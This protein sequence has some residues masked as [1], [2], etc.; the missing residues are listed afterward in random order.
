M[1]VHDTHPTPAPPPLRLDEAGWRAL[2]AALLEIADAQ[3][4][5]AR[6]A[7]RVLFEA[8]EVALGELDDWANADTAWAAALE[9]SPH[10]GPA[11]LARLELAITRDAPSAAAG[12]FEAV[13]RAPE[14]ALERRETSAIVE[15]CLLAW[16]FRWRDL[17]RAASATEALRAA[18]GAERLV[19]PLEA[20]Y[21]TPDTQRARLEAAA[22]RASTTTERAALSAALGTLLLD[23]FDARDLAFAALDA[24]A[25]ESVD[26]AWL[27]C[28]ASAEVSDFRALVAALE[29]LSRCVPR[30]LAPSVL[31]VCGELCE[32]RLLDPMR[33]DA[34]YERSR[35]GSMHVAVSIRRVVQALAGAATSTLPGAGGAGLAVRRYA[36]EAAALDEHALGRV[37]AH[38]AIAHALRAGDASTAERLARAALARQPDDERA[39][40]TLARGAWQARRWAVFDELW[41][42]RPVREDDP[43]AAAVERLVRGAVAEHALFDLKA[44]A[45]AL[46]AQGGVH[47]A[48]AERDLTALRA[49]Q[50]VLV[51]GAPSERLRAWQHEADATDSPDR[52]LDLFLKIARSLLR[53]THE[54]EKALTYLLWVLDGGESPT[55]A[56]LAEVVGRARGSDRLFRDTL[57][58]ARTEDAVSPP[59][60]TAA[61][62]L[63]V[64]VELDG[65]P[66]DP[67][68]SGEVT[69]Y[70]LD[71][72]PGAVGN[73]AEV[74][75]YARLLSGFSTLP[76]TAIHTPV[77]VPAPSAAL[78]S[79]PSLATATPEPPPRQRGVTPVDRPAGLS[80]EVERSRDAEPARAVIA[81]KLKR[82]RASGADAPAASPW[83]TLERAALEPL[84]ARVDAAARER[85]DADERA[86]A[87]AALARGYEAEQLD[88]LATRAWAEVLA[89]RARD[90]DAERR[91]EALLRGQLEAPDD[92]A[93]RAQNS[94]LLVDVLLR[95]AERAAS[96]LEKCLALLDVSSVF[97]GPMRAPLEAA[98]ALRAVLARGLSPTDETPAGRRLRAERDAVV[99]ALQEG[100]HLQALMRLLAWP[101]RSAERASGE[102]ALHVGVLWMG[103]QGAPEVALPWLRRAA[104]TLDAWAPRAELAVCLARLGRGGEATELA[105][106]LPATL[107]EAGGARLRVADALEARGAHPD[108]TRALYIAAFDA[109]CAARPLLERLERG[110]LVAKDWALLAR[111]TTAQLDAAEARGRALQADATEAAAIERAALVDEQRDL[112]VRLGHLYAKRLEMADRAAEAFLRAYRLDPTDHGLLRVLEGLLARHAAPALQIE[113]YGLYLDGGQPGAREAYART[114]TLAGLLEQAG[115]AGDAIDRLRAL[116]RTPEVEATIERLLPLA[117]RW[118]EVAAT[119]R[120]RLRAPE[121]DHEALLRRLASVLETG[122]RD[123]TGATDALRELLIVRPDDLSVVKGL[124]RLLEGQRRWEALVEMSERELALTPDARPQAWILFRIG[125][126]YE[127]R[128]DR[129]EAA[130]RCYRRAV[131][132]DPRCFPALHGLREMAVA[133]GQW[134]A[135]LDALAREAEL[136]DEPRER[137]AIYARM[138]EVFERHLND[139]ARAM[140]EHRRAVATYPACLPSL[141]ALADD[142]IAR[143]AWDE[144]APWLQVL[145]AQNLDRWSKAQRAHVLIQR[146]QV[147]LHLSRR[148]EAAE[149]MRLALDLAPEDTQAL[150][151]LVALGPLT[152]GPEL[153]EVLARIARVEQGATDD[154]RR[155]QCAALR[156]RALARALAWGKADAAFEAARRLQPT[157][158]DALR[159]W[160][161]HLIATCRLTLAAEALRAFA[162]ALAAQGRSVTHGELDAIAQALRWA[163]IL[164]CDQLEAPE[165]GLDALQRWLEVCPESSDAQFERALCLRLLGRGREARDGLLTLLVRPESERLKSSVRARWHHALGRV[166]ADMLEDTAGALVHFEAAL[167][168]DPRCASAAL[169]W[170]RTTALVGG[171]DAAV[172]IDAWLRDNPHALEPPATPDP[173]YGLLCVFVAKHRRARGDRDGARSALHPLTTREGPTTRDAQLTLLEFAEA[174]GRLDDAL[175]VLAAMLARDVGDLD[176]LRRLA[177]LAARSG[178]DDRLLTTLDALGLYGSLEPAEA[179]RLGAL[180]QRQA[181]AYERTPRPVPE[182]LL[183]DQ[184]NHPAFESPL[185]AAL[186]ALEPGLAKV[187][188]EATPPVGRRVERPPA[189]WRWCVAL[190]GVKGATLMQSDAQEAPIAV[191]AGDGPA[192]VLGPRFFESG[193]SAAHRRFWLGHALWALRTGTARLHGLEAER[194]VEVMGVVE[195]LFTP[196][197]AESLQARAVFDA[198]PQRVADALGPEL[199][200]RRQGTL[201]A[202][203]TGESALAGVV[204]SGD[205]FGL[206]AS[207][208]LRAALECAAGLTPD[209]APDLAWV[210]RASPRM[211][212]LVRWGISE[213]CATLRSVTGLGP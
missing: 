103:P 54:H 24:S 164:W 43:H 170:L 86:D 66:T 99:A 2:Y 198:L 63:E 19:A 110:A 82:A 25:D 179:A 125:S 105:L 194:A 26:A 4:T 71:P 89:W 111:V 148:L 209:A 46:S 154:A 8:G 74:D 32:H 100:H 83:L 139:R 87:L 147:A 189:E 163:A 134:P 58:R 92:E 123:L 133:A 39:W 47:R 192:V 9:H 129:P 202:L 118:A 76:A 130:A 159:P 155:S 178:R 196:S 64:E 188:G 84:V 203:Y 107:P 160:I 70:P 37:F 40:M 193:V 42:A 10:F 141:Q 88:P 60:P 168:L 199:E 85:A 93:A 44:A 140:A 143:R 136:W 184:L 119:L 185:I 191:Y 50:R 131:G 211:Q 38:R 182:G 126:L 186:G 122:L 95:R 73:A 72:E 151:V 1:I 52:R 94:R 145:T 14:G 101:E 11:L 146:G 212:D 59:A 116:P 13:L 7:T 55:A 102:A 12:V 197:A 61:S 21:E 68:W 132:L 65:P 210:V 204:R 3:G 169:A 97:R 6:R 190:T 121:A 174:D 112:A 162:D 96:P 18:E 56:R 149:C 150:E 205:R 138:A 173:A 109:G 171:A 142:A 175:E 77:P 78:A 137:A 79:L 166:L 157:S 120:E 20:L 206:W 127:T 213:Q 183:V 49:L 36:E 53:H 144:A 27:L 75:P 15:T 152:E 45:E 207:G 135:V 153:E 69:P 161:E 31:H 104:E 29:R 156:G 22:S 57:A 41:R 51:G 124:C 35:G 165:R 67:D 80:E 177:E 108:E 115:R 181:R 117:G 90:L 81:A 114:L 5:H 91:L 200:R 17:E 98:E 187:F 48:R 62:A 208:A 172:R 106:A 113:L 176:A 128:L 28:E 23:A 33:A 195:A 158:I 180:R 16:V 30:G 167:A 201:P 34:F